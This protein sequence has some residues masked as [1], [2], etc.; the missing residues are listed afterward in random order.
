MSR[1][2][3]EEEVSNMKVDKISEFVRLMSESV[4]EGNPEVDQLLANSDADNYEVRKMKEVL[5]KILVNHGSNGKRSNNGKNA[6]IVKLV[7]SEGS[8]DTISF[9]LNPKDKKVNVN[10]VEEKVGKKIQG[11]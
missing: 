6:K 3:E 9:V 7:T 8:N 2:K 11:I 5:G 10:I 4:R 1:I